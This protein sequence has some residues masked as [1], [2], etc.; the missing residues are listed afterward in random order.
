MRILTRHIGIS[1]TNMEKSLKFYEKLLGF[2][3][4]TDD[5]ESG[6]FVSHITGI[7]DCKVR[8]VKLKKD[9]NVLVELLDFGKDSTSGETKLTDAGLTHF[10]LTVKNLMNLYD[11]LKSSGVEF[12]GYPKLSPSKKA[13]VAFCIDP[14][15]VFIELVEVK[16]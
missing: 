12:I 2:R 1:T 6:E 9:D 13:K 8:T 11:I 3:K 5:Y 15:G 4:I 16:K 14:N 7:A 10:A